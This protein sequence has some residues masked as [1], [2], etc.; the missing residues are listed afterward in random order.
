MI[1]EIGV[2]EDTIAMIRNFSSTVGLQTVR[3]EGTM[4]AQSGETDTESMRII[5]V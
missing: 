5:E 4:H 1:E 3:T 2:S